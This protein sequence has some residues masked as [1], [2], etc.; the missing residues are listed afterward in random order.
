VV[1]DPGEATHEAGNPEGK[2]MYKAP[3]LGRRQA[4]PGDPFVD[5]VDTYPEICKPR[6]N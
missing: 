5:G 2:K 4:P 1:D 6:V 3:G